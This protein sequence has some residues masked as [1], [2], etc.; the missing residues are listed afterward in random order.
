MTEK[1]NKVLL[2]SMGNT[3][4]SPAAEYLAKYYSKKKGLE[5][6]FDSAGFINAFSYMQ[7]E[8]QQY[9]NDKGINHS[10]FNPKIIDKELKWTL[11]RHGSD[12]YYF[13]RSS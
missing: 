5:I 8:S 12:G 6:R 10:D 9:L 4:R 11:R 2:V 13:S 7:P 3:A 1:I